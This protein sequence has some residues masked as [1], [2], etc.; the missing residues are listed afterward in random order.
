MS[1]VAGSKISASFALIRKC[2]T[3]LICVEITQVIL[4]LKTVKTPF[5]SFE[6]LTKKLGRF[7]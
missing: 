7:F 4:L 5:C 1:S 3:G 6:L 2:P